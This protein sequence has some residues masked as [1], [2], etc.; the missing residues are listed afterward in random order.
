[1]A[2]NFAIKRDRKQKEVD[3]KRG[4]VRAKR[5]GIDVLTVHAEDLIQ[6]TD[7]ERSRATALV[8]RYEL[9]SDNFLRVK[10]MVDAGRVTMALAITPASSRISKYCALCGA[11]AE[12]GRSLQRC[13]SCNKISFCSAQCMRSAWKHHG[14]KSFCGESLP[15]IALIEAGSPAHVVSSLR[16]FGRWQI[17]IALSCLKRIERS[18]A[19]DDEQD[20]V[21]VGVVNAVA[22]IMKAHE[23]VVVQ[24][25]CVVAMACL[26]RNEQR[27]REAADSGAIELVLHAAVRVLTSSFTAKSTISQALTLVKAFC[28]HSEALRDMAVCSGAI[29]V[30]A[31]FMCWSPTEALSEARLHSSI[32]STSTYVLESLCSASDS[33]QRAHFHMRAKLAVRGLAGLRNAR[34]KSNKWPPW[35]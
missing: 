28:E 7:E 30:V 8:R 29:E 27:V 11:R 25:A 31:I 10:L 23:E 14:H 9:L 21:S 13:G 2:F 12:A 17:E 18:A 32:T 35:G 1:V 26:L 16:L 33:T 22:E 15:T 5:E 3:A 24:E 20:W 4:V 34:A 6:P 19:V